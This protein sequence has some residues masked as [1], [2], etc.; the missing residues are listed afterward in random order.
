MRDS[1]RGA[2]LCAPTY[3][4]LYPIENLYKMA[5]LTRAGGFCLCSSE[6]YSPKFL[7]LSTD[8]QPLQSRDNRAFIIQNSESEPRSREQNQVTSRN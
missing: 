3:Y 8:R 2:Q 5:V 6:F 1:S 7:T 4:V